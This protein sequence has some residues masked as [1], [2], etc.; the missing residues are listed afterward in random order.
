MP[1]ALSSGGERFLDAEEVRGSNPLAPTK[2]VLLEPTPGETLAAVQAQLL[3][4]R[5][6][7]EAR[8][9]LVVGVAPQASAESQ[10]V[11]VKL[12]VSLSCAEGGGAYVTLS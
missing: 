7:H 11:R 8:S 2:P 10:A 1:R 5:D 6:G 3:A 4:A 9:L 12:T